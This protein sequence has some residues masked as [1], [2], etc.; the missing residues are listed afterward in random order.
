M[1]EGRSTEDVAALLATAGEA[2]RAGRWEEARAGFETALE[3]E[4]SG[5]AL[6]GLALAL[7]WLRDPVSSVRLQERAFGMFRQAG[8]NEN[9][10]FTAMYLCLG[11][12]MTFGNLSASRG[13]LAKASRVVEDCGLGALRGWL[14]LCEAVALHH[15]DLVAAEGKARE[16]LEV[17]RETG[18][19]DLDMCAR[20][21]SAQRSSSWAGPVRGRRCWT[22]RWRE[23]S[24]ARCMI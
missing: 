5:E 18:E 23:R 21:S 6:F 8:D 1:R 11:Y 9:A 2:L 19:R 15:D 10:F 22:R 16:A 20:A 3:A 4:E 24:V 14:L 17:A 12:D 13:W 7:W